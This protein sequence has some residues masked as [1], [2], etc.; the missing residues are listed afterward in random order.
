MGLGWAV[1]VG[2]YFSVG[3]R[4]LWFREDASDYHGT[5]LVEDAGVL[6]GPWHSFRFGAVLKEMGLDSDGYSLPF[7]LD[8]GASR[9]M[10]WGPNARHA[11]NA[12]VGME[13]YSSHQNRGKL[14][15]EYGFWNSVFLRVGW[16]PRWNPNELSLLQGFS[17]GAG[18]SRSRWSLDYSLS[19]QSELGW[20]QRISISWIYGRKEMP[21]TQA[22]VGPGNVVEIEKKPNVSDGLTKKDSRAFFPP[23][24][25]QEVVQKSVSQTAQEKLKKGADASA[26]PTL[27]QAKDAV[28]LKFKISDEEPEGT[29]NELYMK[30]EAALSEGKPDAALVYYQSCVKQE[31]QFEKAWVC[32]SQIQYQKAME[33]AQKAL[34]ANPDDE[35]LQKW[36]EQ[37]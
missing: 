34:K 37:H 20:E 4:A 33:A 24:E 22:V 10:V 25:G 15:L 16:E 27:G 23:L 9:R 18:L 14:G 35:V 28:I 1:K 32:I 6:M 5:G 19:S 26:P 30:G 29:P 17:M 12:A 21:K 2:N 8:L 11:L 36:L 3:T 31:P 13:L 7:H